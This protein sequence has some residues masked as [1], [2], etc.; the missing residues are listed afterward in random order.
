M[1]C[2]VYQQFMSR[3]L[4]SLNRS[5][6]RPIYRIKQ[7]MDLFI[8]RY[9]RRGN[10]QRRRPEE[11]HDSLIR[12][13]FLKYI[14]CIARRVVATAIR[15]THIKTCKEPVPAVRGAEYRRFGCSV[16]S[17]AHHGIGFAFHRCDDIVFF[18]IFD[19]SNCRRRAYGMGLPCISIPN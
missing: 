12:H 7:L 5:H 11:S 18:Q 14:S 17:L 8:G 4:C 10:M 1:N 13:I 15:F 9:Q 2:W 16:H 6:C 19:S 3:W